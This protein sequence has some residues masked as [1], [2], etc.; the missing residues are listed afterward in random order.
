MK[1]SIYYNVRPNLLTADPLDYM[2]TIQILKSVGFEELATRISKM[3]STVTRTDI[4]AVFEDLVTLSKDLLVEGYRIN[5]GDLC[6]LYPKIKG[7]FVGQTDVFD[8]ARHK[9]EFGARVPEKTKKLMR[10]EVMM[11]KKEVV[12]RAPNIEAFTDG[13][14]GSI[15]ATMTMGN[16][17]LVVGKRFSFD[18]TQADEGL[19]IVD[20]AD[21]AEAVKVTSFSE[22]LPSKLNFLIPNTPL[23]SGEGFFE[24][25]S[26]MGIEGSVVK[27]N[28]LPFSISQV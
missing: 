21:S 3:G 9:V 15:N 5:M 25:R 28:T 12:Q 7:T 24:L 4:L 16:V 6:H 22:K 17:G 10:P 27:T 11:E 8:L 14:S 26:R 23:T 1:K 20:S 18:A 19:Y 2:G 13:D